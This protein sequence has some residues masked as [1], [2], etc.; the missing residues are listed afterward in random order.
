MPKYFSNKLKYQFCFKI[1]IYNRYSVPVMCLSPM[2]PSTTLSSILGIPKNPSFVPSFWLRYADNMSFVQRLY[3]T[4][5]MST[6]LL[7]NIVLKK[8]EQ[9]MLDDLYVYPGHH[10]CPPL[11][12]LKNKISMTLINT[13]YSVSYPRPYPANVIPVAGMHLM[14]SSPK[15]VNQVKYIILFNE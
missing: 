12:I 10:K 1:L 15:I 3:N 13:H 5:M 8:M 7:F 2:L 9:N 11:N 4:V 6:E 14:R